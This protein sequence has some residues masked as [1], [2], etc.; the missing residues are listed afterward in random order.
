MLTFRQKILISYVAVFL[1]FIALLYPFSSH[2]IKGLVEKAMEDRATE[3]IAKIQDAP[4]DDGL[5]RRLKD[6]KAGLFFRVSI[7]T[8]QRKVLYDSH[9]KRILGPRFTQDYTINHPEVTLAFRNGVGF[10]VGYSELLQ[11]KFAYMAKSFDFHGKKYVLRTAFPYEYV[12]ELA[13]DFE[14]GFLGL[15]IAILLLFSTMTWFIIHHFTKP[16]DEIINAV[17]PYK[18]GIIDSLPRVETIS[19]NPNED[20]GKLAMTLNSLSERIQNHI[21]SLIEERNEKKAV[22]ESLVEGVIAIEPDMTVSFANKMALKFFSLKEEDLIGKNF[23][24]VNEPT[25]Y[26]LI[27]QCQKENKILSE[28]LKIKKRGET[29]YFNLVAA[30]TVE[31]RGAILVLQ[32]M[33]SQFK[34]MEMRR[35][36]VANASHELKTPITIIRGFAETLHDN[37]DLPDETVE[38][39][40]DKIVTN[41]QRMHTLVK[42]LLTLT[43]IEHIPEARL[44]DCELVDMI[45]SCVDTVKEIYPT[46][47][48]HLI[49][50][51]EEEYILPADPNLLEMALINLIENGAKY[52]TPPSKHHNHSRQDR[53]ND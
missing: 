50:K 7:I 53:P 14:M 19:S 20:F 41:C 34:I 32:D 33:T 30:P 8:D 12:S 9:T 37:P 21:N 22:L 51:K 16:I 35:D 38:L 46:A 39:I 31:K 11:Q 45:L 1:T 4:S 18:E 49:K 15:G 17:R 24:K 3:I 44:M 28:T 25:S 36:F 29:Q 10:H 26:Q 48:I 2:I 40:T 47:T 43:D 52:S 23:G 27:T 5:I 6:Q 42:D 13:Q